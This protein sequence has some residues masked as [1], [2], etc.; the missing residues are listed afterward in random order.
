MSIFQNGKRDGA[1]SPAP[2]PAPVLSNN[3]EMQALLTQIAELT[4][5]I[6]VA[7][8]VQLAGGAE[9]DP[10]EALQRLAAAA[11]NIGER[12]I[13]DD[14]IGDTDIVKGDEKSRSTLD[15]LKEL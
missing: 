3:V 13:V 14:D 15:L 2:A 12:R 11:G 6:A 4:K 7:Q 8:G 1:V 9:V 5:S 10:A